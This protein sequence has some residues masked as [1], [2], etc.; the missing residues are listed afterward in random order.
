MG[1]AKMPQALNHDDTI[2]PVTSV[3]DTRVGARNY[4]RAD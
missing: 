4:E 1:A 3:I 2:R